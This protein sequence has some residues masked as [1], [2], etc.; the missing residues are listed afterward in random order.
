[1]S[2]ERW[3]NVSLSGVPMG[4]YLFMIFII[5]LQSYVVL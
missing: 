2:F 1:M 3:Q 5:L 4:Q